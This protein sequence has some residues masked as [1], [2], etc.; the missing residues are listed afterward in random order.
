VTPPPWGMAASPRPQ[1]LLLPC[2]CRNT[3]VCLD[4]PWQG[5]GT[6]LGSGIFTSAAILLS[7]L[8]PQPP[9][10]SG[11][12]CTLSVPAQTQNFSF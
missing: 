3:S 9:V 1:V 8:Q 12:Y 2:S 5:L 11:F 6:G 10:V 4:L 7:F